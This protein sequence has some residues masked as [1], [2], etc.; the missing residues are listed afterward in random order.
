MGS[1]S[2]TA[3][4]LST[5]APAAASGG[6]GRPGEPA[7]ERTEP[8]LNHAGMG[9]CACTA[10]LASAAHGAPSVTDSGGSRAD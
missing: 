1:S 6:A 10:M 9:L 7:R 8:R 4:I 3:R 2:T 5:S